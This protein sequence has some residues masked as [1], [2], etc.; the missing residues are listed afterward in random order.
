MSERR[1]RKNTRVASEP[2]V[3]SSSR[4]VTKFAARLLIR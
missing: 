2:A 1:R 3:S 4:K